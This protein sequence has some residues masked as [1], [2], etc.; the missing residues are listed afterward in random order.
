MSKVF[1]EIESIP[2]ICIPASSPQPE[3]MAYVVA[4]GIEPWSDNK[5]LIKIRLKYNGKLNGRKVPSIP[6]GSKDWEQIVAAVNELK[7][8]W[9]EKRV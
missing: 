6:L 8:K 3:N 5:P 9:E 2:P 7:N 4:I 1:R